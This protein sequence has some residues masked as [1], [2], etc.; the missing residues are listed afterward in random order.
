MTVATIVGPTAS[1]KSDLALL[2]AAATGAEI[3][4]ADS[5][6]GYR[7]MDIG[8]AKPSRSDRE[9]IPH[10]VIDVWDPG[11]DLSVVEF[12][13]RAR[14]AVADITARG[15]P[16]LIVGGSWLYVQAIV[17][18]LDFP[19]TDPEVRAH[20]EAEL[21]RVGPE[22]LH[23]RLRERDPEAAAAIPASNARRIVRA[24]EV[25]DLHG[26]FRA[27]LPDPQAHIVGPRFGIRVERDDLDRRIETRVDR[28]WAEG[29]V[30]EVAGLRDRGL[31]R[32][33]AG[34]LGYRQVL[35]Y[36]GGDGTEAEAREATIHGTRRFARRQQ[37]R[38]AQDPRVT[39]VD[40]G[41]VAAIAAAV[42]A[43]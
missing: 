21:S 36:L 7:G 17:D 27:R 8:T 10:H 37:R 24:L 38:F 23:E 11:H 3:V 40:P 14:A 30:D 20:W 39:W 16:C 33:A 13:D 5:M 43:T 28:M 1:G 32:T 42:T 9:R 41:D 29:L 2:V 34:A 18:E 22:E 31:G 25:V 4:N 12:R 26:S 15:R 19:G 6:Q 35:A